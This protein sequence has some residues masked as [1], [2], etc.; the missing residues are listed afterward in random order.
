MFY[1]QV[2]DG[3]RIVTVLHKSMIPGSVKLTQGE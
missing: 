3:V 1:R 2:Q